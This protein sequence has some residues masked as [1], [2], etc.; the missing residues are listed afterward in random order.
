MRGYFFRC[1]CNCCAGGAPHGIGTASEPS[2]DK[3]FSSSG[4]S[5]APEH[6]GGNGFSILLAVHNNV[7]HTPVE[8]MLCRFVPDYCKFYFMP[9]PL[10]FPISSTKTM[11]DVYSGGNIA[12]VR[13]ALDNYFSIKTDYYCDIG[14]TGFF[15]IFDHIGGLYY[16]VPQNIDL[17]MPDGSGRLTLAAKADNQYL[18]GHKLYGTNCLPGYG[19]GDFQHLTV[20]SNIMNIFATQKARRAFPFQQT[21]RRYFSACEYKRFNG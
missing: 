15:K 20:Q 2:S 10:D 12:A 5:S 21:I 6:I 18:D 19:G 13:D 17:E 14:S 16:I 1:R 9:I 7:D 8:F 4:T 3:S 11:T